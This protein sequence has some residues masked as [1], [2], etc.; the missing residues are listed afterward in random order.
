MVWFPIFWEKSSSFV[1]SFIRPFVRS[2]MHSLTDAQDRGMLL[3]TEDITPDEA[4]LAPPLTGLNRLV[5]V[6]DSG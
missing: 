3:G 2:F 6:M 1:H 4:V 5:G